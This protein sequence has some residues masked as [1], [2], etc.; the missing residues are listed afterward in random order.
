MATGIHA[1]A[2]AAR[3][4]EAT[5]SQWAVAL[6]FDGKGKNDDRQLAC[7]KLGKALTAVKGPYG[8][9]PFH[10]FRCAADDASVPPTAAWTITF[11]S[12]GT[13]AS[14]T[15]AARISG[16]TLPV[17]SFDVPEASWKQLGKDRT[18]T[19]LAALIIDRLP[20]LGAITSTEA[21]AAEFSLKGVAY[22]SESP[23]RE[24]AVYR[25][26]FDVEKALWV[27]ELCDT[28][29]LTGEPIVGG[30][31]GTK[32]WTYRRQSPTACLGVGPLWLHALAGPGT[33]SEALLLT[34][35]LSLDASL[36]IRRGAANKPGF[37]PEGSS[38]YAGL[39]VG[40]NVLGSGKALQKFYYV[41]A[42][43]ERQAFP[44]PGLRLYVEGVP[45]VRTPD[46]QTIKKFGWIRA[47]VAYAFGLD[48]LPFIDSLE[49]APRLG[50]MSLAAE[51]V[52]EEDDD[53][54]PQRFSIRNQPAFGV[55]A[56]LEKNLGDATLR[57]WIGRDF[58][59][60]VLERVASSDTSSL[61]GGLDAFYSLT[62]N[63]RLAVMGFALGESLKIVN[64]EGQELSFGL[65]FVGA[66]LVTSW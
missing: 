34:Y 33:Q 31:K 60:P 14:V 46:D 63:K 38:G 26:S 16:A 18:A 7:A 15:I 39:R 50:L 65:L 9:G 13:K 5:E 56:S 6:N 32:V 42:L 29:T 58:V 21:N 53:G 3:A 48:D 49:V 57:P 28:A 12:G 54:P 44:V 62:T 66:G 19:A 61:A 4:V 1:Y 41:S 47:Q 45:E 24:L 10:S 25:L 36:S 37:S 2:P 40:K 30:D 59:L 27:P 8:F 43:L 20:A 52:P 51:I 23:Y 11:K 64:P 22:G 55:L 35:K 17:Q